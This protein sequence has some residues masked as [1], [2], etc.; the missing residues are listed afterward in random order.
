MAH[1]FTVKGYMPLGDIVASDKIMKTVCFI[2]LAPI[3]GMLISAF[4][5]LVTI[6]RNLWGRFAIMI[7]ASGMTFLIFDYFMDVK[8]EQNLSK[9]YRV[10][11][12]API[13]E[14]KR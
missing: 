13:T 5:T 10:E 9:F 8:L 11:K 3:I 2:F 12:L 7:L 6:K 4:I 14:T 1:A